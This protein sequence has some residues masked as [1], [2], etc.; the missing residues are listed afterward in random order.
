MQI[1]KRSYKYFKINAM[2]LFVI[3]RKIYNNFY[4]N[5]GVLDDFVVNKISIT[6]NLFIT[7]HK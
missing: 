1:I 7:F 3:K 5:V 4:E 2:F 6:N